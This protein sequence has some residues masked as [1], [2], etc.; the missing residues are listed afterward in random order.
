MPSEGRHYVRFLGDGRI[1]V[2]RR[3]LEVDFTAHLHAGRASRKQ[4]N[5][6]SRSSLFIEHAFA[7]IIEY[8]SRVD[9]ARH[10]RDACLHQGS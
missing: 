10:S 8:Q 7:N 6:A 1:R 3:S 5:V 2:E 9:Q 4:V